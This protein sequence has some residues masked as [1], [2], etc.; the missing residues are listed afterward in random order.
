MLVLLALLGLGTQ[1][2]LER[3]DIGCLGGRRRSVRGVGGDRGIGGLRC[4]GRMLTGCIGR[5]SI[6]LI[7][8]ALVL[9]LFVL[10]LLFLLFELGELVLE[11]LLG[12]LG[13]LRLRLKLLGPLYGLSHSTTL[14]SDACS[15][16]FAQL[17]KA[18]V[19]GLQ[20]GREPRRLGL[21]LLNAGLG[22]STLLLGLLHRLLDAAA[23]QET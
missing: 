6:R 9:G 2:L 12:F 17:L 18:L 4:L 22:L 14:L 15:D 21:G 5:G 11:G 8:R 20:L 16:L 3:G 7:L 19:G 10:D 1:L 13:R 23:L